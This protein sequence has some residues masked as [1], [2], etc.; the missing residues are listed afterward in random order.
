MV[1][2]YN[3]KAEQEERLMRS[4][5]PLLRF[6]TDRNRT[7]ERSDSYAKLRADRPPT[8]SLA[9]ERRNCGSIHISRRSA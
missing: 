6:G 1:L 2:A 3:R 9:A 4:K 5:I 8:R 7:I